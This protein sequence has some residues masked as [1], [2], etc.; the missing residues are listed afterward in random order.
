MVKYFFLSSLLLENK[1]ENVRQ[2]RW[3]T[4]ARLRARK[5]VLAGK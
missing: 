5:G 3:P 1:R 4:K 2:E